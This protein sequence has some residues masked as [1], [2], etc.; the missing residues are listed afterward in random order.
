[1]RIVIEA[2]NISAS[3]TLAATPKTTTI[4]VATAPV[5]GE[6]R[7]HDFNISGVAGTK[8]RQAMVVG[9]P[10]TTRAGR[11]RQKQTR[12]PANEPN[13]HWLSL[14]QIP[15]V[16]PQHA[17]VHQAACMTASMAGLHAGYVI[18][19]TT[20]QTIGNAVARA[21]AAFPTPNQ[22]KK[23]ASSLMDS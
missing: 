20:N 12:L 1:M 6:S 18:R 4:H 5:P 9:I 15:E 22:T 10:T 3:A 17:P 2:T 14:R 19:R 11:W 21:R 7:S 16:E 13:S 8:Y 23:T